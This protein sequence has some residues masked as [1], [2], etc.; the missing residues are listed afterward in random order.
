MHLDAPVQVKSCHLR[1]VS[2][3]AGVRLALHHV[4]SAVPEGE[5]TEV[6][7]RGDRPTGGH[8][9]TT[10]PDLLGLK[11]TFCPPSSTNRAFSCVPL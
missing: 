10:D 5:K 7:K 6:N 11:T 3:I 9:I 2:V 8:P 1:V 4:V